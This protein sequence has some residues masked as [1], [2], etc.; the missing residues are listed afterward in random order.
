[1]REV[2]F[3]AIRKDNNSYILGSSIFRGLD[4]DN[5]VK[6]FIVPPGGTCKPFDHDGLNISAM[7]AE[8]IQVD[9]ET[10][11]VFQKL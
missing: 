11:E 7:K 5:K 8:F 4:R 2:V 10:I 3:R 9:P 1:M 6:I